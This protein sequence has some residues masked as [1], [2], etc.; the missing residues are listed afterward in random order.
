MGAELQPE[1][2]FLTIVIKLV[3]IIPGHGQDPER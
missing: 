3:L 2:E 1:G